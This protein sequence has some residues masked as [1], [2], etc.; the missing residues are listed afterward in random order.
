MSPQT[1]KALLLFG[2]EDHK[3]FLGCLNCNKFKEDSVCNRFGK[4]GSKFETDSIWNQ[5]GTFGS[6]FNE[7]SPW[8]KFS[9]KAPI[10]VDENGKSYGY[11]SMNKFH[12]DRTHI[13]WLVEILDY[14]DENDD[15]DMT[16]DKM[17]G[18]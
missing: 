17:C 14:Q 15:L 6:T 1:S 18:D 4:F 10:I 5:F 2:G 3:T 12:Q 8:N 13:K 11:F 16:R 7:F 9:S